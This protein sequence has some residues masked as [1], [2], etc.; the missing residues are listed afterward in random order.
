MY[1]DVN[2]DGKV[3]VSDYTIIKNYIMKKI[4]LSTVALKGADSNRSGS[5]TASDYTI[6]KNFVYHGS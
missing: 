3:T 5:V 4:N 1:G 6:I 2:G